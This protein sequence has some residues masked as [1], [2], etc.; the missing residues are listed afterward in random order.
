MEGHLHSTIFNL[1]VLGRW[2][3]PLHLFLLQLSCR[4][5]NLRRR[6]RSQKRNLR[7][8]NKKTLQ[9]RINLRQINSQNQLSAMLVV[10]QAGLNLHV[11]KFTIL[12]STFHP[13]KIVCQGN[14]EF[15]PKGRQTQSNSQSYLH[16]NTSKLT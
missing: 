2:M 1:V 7:R 14:L 9:L 10:I 3:I 11:N 6:R 13:I 15:L 8:R 5:R 16:S 4:K 12:K